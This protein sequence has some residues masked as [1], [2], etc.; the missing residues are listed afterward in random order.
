MF[1]VIFCLRYE[2]FTWLW[3][4]AC[5][6]VPFPAKCLPYFNYPFFTR[7]V[8]NTNARIC[9]SLQW[10]R[11][12]CPFGQ[13]LGN[14]CD[15]CRNVL[16]AYGWFCLQQIVMVRYGRFFVNA[17]RRTRALNCWSQFYTS[18]SI[19][20]HFV[21]SIPSMT[22][23]SNSY[24]SVRGPHEDL[25]DNPRGALWRLRNNSGTWTY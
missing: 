7:T 18:N 14:K 2:V 24:L 19:N 23:A 1:S 22:R 6:A 11:P 4:P 3:F 17:V 13:L 21:C 25:W 20:L 8:N 10:K 16:S 5:F 12:I 9:I 15:R